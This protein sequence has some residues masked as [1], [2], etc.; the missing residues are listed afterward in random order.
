M[1]SSLTLSNFKSFQQLEDLKIK[2][3]TILCGAN[4]CGKSSIL[5]SLLLLKQTKESRSSN[6][7]LLLNGKYVHLGDIENIIHGKDKAK[8]TS[9]TYEY[10]FTRKNL[11]RSKKGGRQRPPINNMFRFILSRE[12]RGLK[13]CTYKLTYKF[14]ANVSGESKGYIKVADIGAFKVS[15][16]ITEK[17]G[18]VRNGGAVEVKHDGSNSKIKWDNVPN[19]HHMH[20]PKGDEKEIS[21]GEFSGLLVKFENLFPIIDFSGAEDFEKFPYEIRNFLR[22]FDDFLIHI[23]EGVTYVG[24][25]R[26]EP[27]RRYIYENEVLEIG[28]KGENAAYIY[29]TEQDTV[30]KNHF[31]YD[32]ITNGFVQKKESTLEDS[33]KLWLDQMNIKGFSPDHQSEII[34]LNMDANSSHGTRVNIADVGFGVSQI[35]PILLEGLRM[36]KQGSLLLE[37]PEI[38]LH[39]ALQMQMADYFLSLA[40]SEKNVLVETHS[41]HIINR[42]VRRIVEDESNK[43]NDMIAIYFVSN[44]DDGATFEEVKLDPLKGIANWPSGFFDQ[45]ANEQEK[46]MLAGIKKRKAARGKNK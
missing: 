15:I 39:P 32:E 33:L 12:E 36:Q 11:I 22:V 35:F 44:G 3:V 41:E 4:S 46:I 9:C 45:T 31:F 27:S 37:Q 1:L 43:L 26:E 5:Q 6:Q 34:R 42:L 25:L 21:S 18:K 10:E 17:D 40:L 28:S 20:G 13:D 16:S 24:P 7:A 19:P 14:K 29:Q 23:N 30:L 2:P 38:H 8:G